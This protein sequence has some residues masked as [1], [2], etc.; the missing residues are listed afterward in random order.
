[1][2]SYTKVEANWSK[3]AQDRAWKRNCYINQGH[4]LCIYLKTITYLQSQTTPIQNLI[5]KIVNKN[6][7]R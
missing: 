7:D 1:M 4:L 5:R 2:N 6:Q 3:D